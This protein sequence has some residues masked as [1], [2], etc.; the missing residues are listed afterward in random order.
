[1]EAKRLAGGMVKGDY[2]IRGVTASRDVGSVPAT[3]QGA[4]WVG[5]PTQAWSMEPGR[6]IALAIAGHG[7][8]G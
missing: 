1:M 2:R 4:R 3:F 8:D 5:D 7:G 6:W